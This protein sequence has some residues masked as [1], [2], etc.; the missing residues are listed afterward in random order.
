M[1]TTISGGINF[2]P[3]NVGISHE[4]SHKNYPAF[5]TIEMS[6]RQAIIESPR[7]SSEKA[8]HGL[9][10]ATYE[11]EFDGRLFFDKLQPTKREKEISALANKLQN[12]TLQA[13]E[14]KEA[15]E[16][17]TTIY[18]KHFPDR[19]APSKELLY[20]FFV[21]PQWEGLSSKKIGNTSVATTATGELRPL[22]S[23]IVNSPYY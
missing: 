22:A 1:S 5:F 17:L 23:A 10:V 4:V 7:Y 19:G 9:L 14:E 2:G 3:I 15:F 6:A 18:Q 11:G 12:N 20:R 21:E 13:A 16:T 8:L